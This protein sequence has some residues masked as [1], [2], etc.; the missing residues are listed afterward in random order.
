MN[1]TD[2]RIMRNGS[3]GKYYLQVKKKFLWH[4]YWTDWKYSVEGDGC[5]GFVTHY[6]DSPEELK[7]AY[8]KSCN[9]KQPDSV[10]GYI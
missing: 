2:K 8:E 9:R 10:I 6:F 5:T 3:H 7:A 1:E 4:E